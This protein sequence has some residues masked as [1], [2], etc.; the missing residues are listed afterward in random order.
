VVVGAGQHAGQLHPPQALRQAGQLGLD[1]LGHLLVVLGL[2]QLQQL[3]VVLDLAGQLVEILDRLGQVGPLLLDLGRLLG[4]VPEAGLLDL[5]VDGFY[6][7]ALASDVK[8]APLA[9]PACPAGL[10]SARSVPGTWV[11]APLE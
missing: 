2:G 8:E 5:L 4:V 1:A 3:L 6:P 7:L 11:L 10:P 9:H